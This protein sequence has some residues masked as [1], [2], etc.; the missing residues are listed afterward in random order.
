M[1]MK[2][3]TKRNNS[4]FIGHPLAMTFCF[5]SQLN[6]CWSLKPSMGNNLMIIPRIHCKDSHELTVLIYNSGSSK[7]GLTLAPRPGS[8]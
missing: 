6:L 1:G 7:P 3:E 8:S 5:S 4:G 2:R